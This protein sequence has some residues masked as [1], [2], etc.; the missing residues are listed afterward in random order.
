VNKTINS[1]IPVGP[2]LL[3]CRSFT[4]TI[5][6]IRMGRSHAAQSKIDHTRAGDFVR[7]IQP[8]IE[9]STVAAISY[10]SCPKMVRRWVGSDNTG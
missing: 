1:E 3:F 7:G 6:Q 4:T 9:Y 10:T 8:R 5:E 2:A